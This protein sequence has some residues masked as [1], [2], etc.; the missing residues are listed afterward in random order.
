M[1]DEA[2]DRSVGAILRRVPFTLTLLAI[3]GAVG[4]ATGTHIEPIAKDWLRQLGFAPKDLWALN[5]ERLFTSAASTHGGAVFWRAVAAISLFVGA[6]EWRAGTRRT[7]EVFVGSHLITLALM[8]IAMRPGLHSFQ[9]GLVE[10]LHRARDVGPSAGYFG[11]L[12]L[13]CSTWVGSL[14]RISI[15]AVATVLVAAL[16][17]ALARDGTRAVSVS[18]AIAHLIAFPVGWALALRSAGSCSGSGSVR[19]PVLT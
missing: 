12:A 5:F 4:I 8:A 14:R 11:T 9:P 2:S 19:P 7:A 16:A 15:G 6:S 17:L 3:L 10:V 13:L 18:A 1:P